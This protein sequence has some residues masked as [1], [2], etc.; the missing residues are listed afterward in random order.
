[1][2]ETGAAKHQK[3][4][5]RSNPIIPM[6]FSSEKEG[7]LFEYMQIVKESPVHTYRKRIES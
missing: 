7:N 1:M 2:P 3:K 4:I 6:K 5:N